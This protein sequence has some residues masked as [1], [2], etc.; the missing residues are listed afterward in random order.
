MT[1]SLIALFA[2][3]LFPW[4]TARAAAPATTISYYIDM[5]PSEFGSYTQFKQ[6]YARVGCMEGER[7]SGGL[8]MLDFGESRYSKRA[9]QWGH[10][11]WSPIHMPPEGLGPW[12][13]TQNMDDAVVAFAGGLV[14]CAR[15]DE[16]YVL[17]LGVNNNNYE[18]VSMLTAGKVWGRMVR[19]IDGRLAATG[20]ART[21]WAI[22][23]VDAEASFGSVSDTV[24]W[25]HGYDAA[26][27]RSRYMPVL[28]F[29]D[30]ECSF[31]RMPPSCLA[32][33]T[34]WWHWW[35]SWGSGHAYALPE[36]Y[37]GRDRRDH[38]T[39]AQKWGRLAAFGVARGGGYGFA[40]TIAESQV[41]PHN[42]ARS[43]WERLD[44]V[45]RSA[46]GVTLSA[47]STDITW[48]LLDDATAGKRHDSW[49]TY[50]GLLVAPA[51]SSAVPFTERRAA[52]LFI[53][54]AADRL[55][56]PGL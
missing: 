55:H 37:G 27:S 32:G 25:I 38:L 48:C 13:T 8:V 39:D 31:A 10:N 42:D 40:G 18:P 16:F 47:L 30:L 21:A 24:A 3:L 53:R 29:G 54:G 15:P 11:A 52:S 4:T 50:N 34:L 9:H 7:S 26:T 51:A 20:A 56:P 49:C 44:E 46:R 45:E 2:L 14:K 5:A 43:A 28:D 6:A 12:M 41:P 35:V 36:I 1:R 23:A 33:W 17:A 19:D 22:G